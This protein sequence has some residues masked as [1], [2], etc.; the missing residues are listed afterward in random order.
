[1]NITAAVHD[2]IAGNIAGQLLVSVNSPELAPAI[3]REI[4]SGTVLVL[5][6]VTCWE[7]LGVP[8]GWP[9][10]VME[11]ADSLNGGWIEIVATP[12]WDTSAPTPTTVK[13]TAEGTVA[14]AVE[15]VMV[16]ED[17]DTIGLV[18]NVADAPAGRPETDRMTG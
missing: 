7:V 11:A 18:P 10:N 6:I 2:A 4:G 17:P 16:V 1:M 13:A 14:V 8:T 15:M 12:V 3:R 5:P 9:A